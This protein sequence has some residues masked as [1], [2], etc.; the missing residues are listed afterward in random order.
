MR[1][2]RSTNYCFIWISYEH[3]GFRGEAGN[4]P[5]WYGSILSRTSLITI[6]RTKKNVSEGR[7]SRRLTDQS[8]RALGNCI[9]GWSVISGYPMSHP[10][11]NSV[12]LG[13]KTPLTRNTS[14]L[15]DGPPPPTNTMV[16]IDN[17]ICV[18]FW[19]SRRLP[20]SST[21]ILRWL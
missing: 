2:D 8:I 20:S 12:P 19:W 1:E 9:R 4:V 7:W 10:K 5:V 6:I 21:H 13:G 3:I 11:K 16:L 14:V 15:I 18:R 17:W